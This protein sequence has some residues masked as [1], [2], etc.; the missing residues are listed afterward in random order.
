MGEIQGIKGVRIGHASHPTQATGVTVFLFEEGAVAGVDIRGS[1]PGTRETELLKPGFLIQKIH[2]LVFTGG[3][4]FGLRTVDGVMDYLS[5][6]NIGYRAGGKVIVP[7]VPAAVIFDLIGSRTPDV[8]S[9]EMGYEAAQQ[10]A[11]TFEE[12]L[13]GAGKGAT[14][15]KIL[16]MDYCMPGGFGSAHTEIPGGIIIQAFAVVNALGDVY[17]PDSGKIIA[18]AR[19]PQGKGFLNAAKFI[20]ENKIDSPLRASNTTLI[21]VLTNAKFSKEM[22][23]K[24]ARMAQN[25]IARTIRPCHTMY[26]GDIVFAISCGEKEADVSVVGEVAA[27]VVG[28][29]IV[30]AVKISNDLK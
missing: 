15:G 7:I 29:A 19:N 16:G 5:E 12:G 23:N 24:I 9:R 25:G 4:A 8:P 13:V 14:V 6:K 30:R 22:I 17:D 10:A 26:D 18:G 21:A 1:A 20:R 28:E 2:A 3:S 11:E 27:Q